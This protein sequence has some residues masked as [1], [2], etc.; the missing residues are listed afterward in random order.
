MI[1][2]DDKPWPV[3]EYNEEYMMNVEKC[4]SDLTSGK[5]SDFLINADWKLEDVVKSLY[6]EAL[7]PDN[8]I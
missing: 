1:I 6:P 7:V 5:Y 4:L 3:D 8:E 2:L